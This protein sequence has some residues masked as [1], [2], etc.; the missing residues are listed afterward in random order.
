MNRIV[1][2]LHRTQHDGPP[3]NVTMEHLTSGK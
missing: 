2:Q 3:V 1:P